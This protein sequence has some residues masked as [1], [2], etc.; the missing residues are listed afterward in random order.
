MTTGLISTAYV[1]G[2]IRVLSLDDVKWGV[3]GPGATLSQ[4]QRELPGHFK[5]TQPDKAIRM[6]KSGNREDIKPYGVGLWYSQGQLCDW[7][8]FI[9]TFTQ[10]RPT[11]DKCGAFNL[12]F[13]L[14]PN[15]ISSVAVNMQLP[16]L[17]LGCMSP[18]WWFHVTSSGGGQGGL[19][20][21]RR[22]SR[23]E[24]KGTGPPLI[25]HS[26]LQDSEITS[27]VHTGFTGSSLTQTISSSSGRSKSWLHHSGLPQFL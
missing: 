21:H 6:T 12:V 27:G 24:E 4:G 8:I 10:L 25:M 20:K 18:F 3:I 7:N 26:H 16:R 2:S 9:A 1:S 5:S 23:R 14:L 22:S 19:L 15:Y 17:A 13:S 11:S